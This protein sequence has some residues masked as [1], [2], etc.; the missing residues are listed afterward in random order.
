MSHSLPVIFLLGPTASGKTGIA[1]ELARRIECQ[2]ISC[3][4]SLV[5]RGMDI[6]T[7]K[8]TAEEQALASHRLI[9]L[10][11]PNEPYS[12]AQYCADAHR[13]ITLAREAG[14]VPILVGGTMLYFNA[15]EQGL[16]SMPAADEDVRKRLAERAARL[17]WEHMHQT[18]S[19]VDPEAARK[20]HPN[21][22]QRIQR[23]L[24]VFELT[25]RPISQWQQDKP[26]ASTALLLPVLKVGLFPTDRAALHERIAKR[27]EQ[28]LEQGFVDE[29]RSLQADDRNH[30]ELPSMRSVGYRQAWQ[31][32]CDEISMDEFRQKSLAATRQLAKRQLTWMRS[33]QDLLLI[34]SLA[35]SQ[36]DCVDQI[37]KALAEIE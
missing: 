22:P 3:D 2:L 19:E 11:E 4:S 31:F 36:D 15:L 18:L 16:A 37:V 32:L 34:D 23:A 7:A 28:M 27:F 12:V 6:G 10:C 25:G 30:A 13:E 1:I 35:L 24:E 9:D 14:R 21:D 17:G 26:D 20:I 33:M 5:Y 29:V 8:P